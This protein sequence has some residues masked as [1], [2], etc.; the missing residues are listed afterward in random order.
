MPFRKLHYPISDMKYTQEIADKICE[1]FATG[2]YTIQDVCQ[3]VD[4]SRK[5]FYSW[6]TEHPEF[7]TAIKEANTRRLE[8]TKHAARSG[9]LTLLQGK[10]YDEVTEEWAG[11]EGS[12]VLKAR[13]VTRKL[14]LPNPTAVIFTLKNLDSENFRDVI[15]QEITGP[16]VVVNRIINFKTRNTTVPRKDLEAV[17]EDKDDLSALL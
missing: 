15:N 6:K 5:T 11:P 13:K 12:Q 16:P 7:A 9:L 8:Q 17:E 1:Q 2:D 3:Q 4:I 14:I 10:E